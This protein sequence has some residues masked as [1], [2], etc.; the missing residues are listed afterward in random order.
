MS[1]SHPDSHLPDR[2]VRV[3]VLQTVDEVNARGPMTAEEFQ[4]FAATNGRCELE[5]G[6]VRLMSPAGSEHGYIANEI[7]F[8][9]TAHVRQ[10]QLGRVY[11]AETGFIIERGPD[12]VRAPDVAFIKSARLP[13]QESRGFGTVMPDLLVE[14]ISPSDTDEMIENKTQL[15]LAAGVRCVVNVFPN[16][17]TAYVHHEKETVSVE[18]NTVID[19]SDVVDDWRPQLNT[20][21]GTQP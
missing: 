12:T 11:A 14:V 4:V 6:K 9:L 5:Q 17:R 3:Q 16:T 8:L 7:G 15:W 13:E 20:F 21:F 10:Y 19:L 2:M 18:G 1:T